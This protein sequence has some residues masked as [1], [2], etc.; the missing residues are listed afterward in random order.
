MPKGRLYP[1]ERVVGCDPKTG[2]EVIQHTCFPAIHQTFYFTNPSM[3]DDGKW[4][5]FVSD[6]EGGWN[7]FAVNLESGEIV[8]LTESGDVNPSSPVPGRNEGRVFFTAGSQVRSVYL[9]TLRE[10]VLAD[11]PG[12][13]LG[14]L[15]LNTWGTRLVTIVYRGNSPALATVSTRSWESRVFYEPQREVLYAQFCPVDD[16][17]VLYASGIH[18]RMWLVTVQG[19]KDRPLYLHNASQWITHESWL[20]NSETVLFTWWRE[21]LMAIQRNGEGLRT[22]IRGPIW[23]ASSR[24][25]GSLIVAD[26]AR[27]DEGLWLIEPI[28]G[29]KVV[30]CYPDASS[31]GSRW[32]E[33]TPESGLVTAETYGPQWT[34]PHPAFSPDGKWVTFTSDRTSFPQIYTARV[35]ENILWK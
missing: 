6:R 31:K 35:P 2:V 3:S 7:L 8:Q 14:G 33:K 26:T 10:S 13:R 25:D 28:S 9:D 17:W 5:F 16:R 1:S 21:G 22:V 34:H 30:L 27:P 29:A 15:S 24:R 11:F 18:Q 19:L 12:A 23:H 32:D 20:G 4:L